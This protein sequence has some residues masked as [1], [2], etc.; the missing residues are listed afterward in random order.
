MSCKQA[1]S[2][3]GDEQA[4]ELIGVMGSQRVEDVTL[5]RHAYVRTARSRRASAAVYWRT[6]EAGRKDQ[7]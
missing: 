1:W 6:F 4:G 5:I 2:F 7:F 3:G